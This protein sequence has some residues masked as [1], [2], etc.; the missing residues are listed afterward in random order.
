MPIVHPAKIFTIETGQGQETWWSALA[1]A[2]D[3]AGEIASTIN[4]RPSETHDFRRQAQTLN[5][6]LLTMYD[7]MVAK[8]SRFYGRH[9]SE[10]EY[11]L[12]RATR[13]LDVP[14]YAHW[15]GLGDLGEYG[16]WQMLQ[17]EDAAVIGWINIWDTP[18]QRTPKR[19]ADG[20][21]MTATIN[22]GML[23]EECAVSSLRLEQCMYFRKYAPEVLARMK[24]MACDS[25]LTAQHEE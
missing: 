6:M 10:S 24:R 8:P 12:L 13:F 14:S 16:V 4:S 20:S 17:Y 11:Y 19:T 21:A 15:P 2:R 25:Q 9:L 22:T 5:S 23:P 7:A 18:Q 1:M 3:M